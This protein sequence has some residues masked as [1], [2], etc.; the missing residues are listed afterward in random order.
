M[1]WEPIT[2]SVA[3][4]KS[5]ILIGRLPPQKRIVASENL[6]DPI[7]ESGSKPQKNTSKKPTDIWKKSSNTLTILLILLIIW[8]P[9][10]FAAGS[11][12][13][14]SYYG[15]EC[16]RWNPSPTCEMANGQS[17]YDAIE[18]GVPYAAMWG[19]KFGTKVKVTGPKGSTTVIVTDRGP[20][21]RLNRLIDLNPESFSKVCERHKGLCWVELEIL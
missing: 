13:T 3:K 16:C 10:I 15:V 9:G 19:P 7:N 1:K 18:R 2:P 20:A 12:G 14:A 11:T 8:A 5:N 17:L 4:M 21:K 6:S